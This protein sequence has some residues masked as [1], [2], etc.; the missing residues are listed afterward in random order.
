MELSVLAVVA[1]TVVSVA[2]LCVTWLV[3]S[4]PLP[5]PDKEDDDTDGFYWDI[6]NPF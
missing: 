2:L 6:Y 4:P 1:A 5:D 3:W